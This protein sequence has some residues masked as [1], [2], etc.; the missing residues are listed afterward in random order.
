M[1]GRIDAFAKDDSGG[2]TPE[3][4]IHVGRGP[5]KADRR[6]SSSRKKHCHAPRRL[7]QKMPVL[8]CIFR[9]TIIPSKIIAHSGLYVL[10]IL[11][12]STSL[13]GITRQTPLKAGGN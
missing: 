9:Q 5:V 7:Y 12:V 1:S 2:V 11:S 3:R 8:T 13:S 6:R 4:E 10:Q